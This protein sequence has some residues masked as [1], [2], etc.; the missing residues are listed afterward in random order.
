MQRSACWPPH[1][2]R[3]LI[4]GRGA[5]P[6]SRLTASILTETHIC[7]R[8]RAVV[9]VTTVGYGDMTPGYAAA[10]SSSMPHSSTQSRDP[11]LRS[12]AHRPAHCMPANAP[13]TVLCRTYFGK[14]FG[15][16]IILCGVIFLAMPLNSVGTHFSN[17]WKEYQLHLLK[18]GMREQLMNKGILPSDV[19]KAF[20]EFDEDGNGLIDG[21]EFSNFI[22]T[23][24]KL[25]L[26]RAEISQLWRSLDIDGMGAVDFAEFQA[27]LFS[28]VKAPGDGAGSEGG[29]TKKTTPSRPATPARPPSPAPAPMARG[30]TPQPAE[31]SAA[32]Q[33]LAA[34][35]RILSTDMAARLGSTDKRVASLEGQLSEVLR[36]LRDVHMMGTVS[37]HRKHRPQSRAA[38][39][40][41]PPVS[42]P[43]LDERER[44]HEATLADAGGLAASPDGGLV[45][46]PEALASSPESHAAGVCPSISQQ[47]RQ[48]RSRT[49]SRQASRSDG[50]PP[51]R[52]R[53]EAEGREDPFFDVDA[54]DAEPT[55]DSP[56][57]RERMRSHNRFKAISPPINAETNSSA[58]SNLVA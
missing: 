54:M 36:L 16:I 33:S 40:R 28:D 15:G 53:R 42:V 24:L 51:S 19:Q 52:G 25:K 4:V 5:G 34:D 14:A 10:R 6:H 17:V 9:T 57:R 32:L 21:N 44:E 20:E 8:V 1:G 46:S 23:V 7:P 35:V 58:G 30:H 38:A 56:E 2:G 50:R 48:T 22:T 27:T 11:E 12:C 39:E 26:S 43:T 41:P 3:P 55:R 45:A 37:R 47:Q 13:P 49:D 18:S 31:Q 29:D